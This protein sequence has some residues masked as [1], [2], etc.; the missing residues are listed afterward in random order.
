MIRG[1]PPSSFR[2]RG[3]AGV[4][5]LPWVAMLLALHRL[6]ASGQTVLVRAVDA[7]TSAPIVGAMVHLTDGARR[8]AKSTL[9]DERGR[10]LFVG[11]A[12]GTYRVRVE[13]I[14]METTE[15]SSFDLT[16]GETISRSV[17]LSPRPVSL[18]GLEVA[19]DGRCSV[20]AAEGAT[21]ARVWEA[22]RKALE[23]ASLTAQRGRYRYETIRY[24]RQIDREAEIILNEETTHREGFMETPYE[25]R[26]AAELVADGFVQ[27][28]GDEDVYF[29]PDA[30]VL[31][32]GAFLDT[33][34]FHLTRNEERPDLI[35][36]GFRPTGRTRDVPDIAGTMWLD[37]TTAEL[38]WLEYTYQYLAPERTSS[39]VGGRVD[40]QRMSD[41]TWIVREW[42]IRMPVM[43]TQTGLEGDR[44][45]YIERYEE[46]G[47]VVVDVRDAGGRRLGPGTTTGGIEG[48][49]RDSLGAPVAAARVALVGSN[50]EVYTDR[51]GAFG[52]TR[53]PGGRYRVRVRGTGLETVGYRH[54]PI[55][56][57]VI[58][59]EMAYVEIHL[60]SLSDVMFD[61]CR[62]EP[63]E[64]DTRV[65]AGTVLDPWGGPVEGA[66]VQVGWN[67]YDFRG[68]T[69]GRRARE[70]NEVPHAF[71]TSTDVDG[72][73]RFCSVP[74]ETR[75][76]L[77]ASAAELVSVPL[78]MSISEL[79]VGAVRVLEVSEPR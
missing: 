42:W 66:T 23:A 22:A 59:G 24:E 19:T 3:P 5:A 72:V 9:T 17:R 54:Q 62:D 2:R 46:E 71:E 44:L 27:T 40:F 41:G 69:S 37:A 30:A 76:F 51:D 45:I 52:L 29:A 28:D 35:G 61:A 36:L 8:I 47:G 67:E 33:H 12:Q 79:E 58:A 78:E 56:Q 74:M 57:D 32:A 77:Q 75:L 38:R 4:R 25:S 48:V 68:V 63:R 14:G 60:P 34:C 73:Y 20:R 53:L 70:L 6:P 15:T 43:A 11:L 39:E 1:S 26:P 16:A 10:G 31:L 55:V 50:Q 13:M 18:E 7:E 49:V 21:V 64:E 65:L